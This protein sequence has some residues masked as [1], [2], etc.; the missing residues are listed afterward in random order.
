MYDF[1][2]KITNA[3]HMISKHNHVR[4][5][6]FKAAVEAGLGPIKQPDGLS[7][8]QMIGEQMSSSPSG[9]KARTPP[10]TSRLSTLFSMPWW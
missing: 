5:A 2:P 3:Q 1:G 10:S 4:D 9:Q 8:V 7:L 6:I